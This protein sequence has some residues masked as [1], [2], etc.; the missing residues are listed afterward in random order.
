[1]PFTN[2]KGMYAHCLGTLF[3]FTFLKQSIILAR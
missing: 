2:V 3:K 1:M